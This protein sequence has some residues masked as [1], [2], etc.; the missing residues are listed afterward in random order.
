MISYANTQVLF[1]NKR[2]LKIKNISTRI[3]QS[4]DVDH[5]LETRDSNL[6]KRQTYIDRI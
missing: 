5:S 6:S 4:K 2:R 1:L 3:A